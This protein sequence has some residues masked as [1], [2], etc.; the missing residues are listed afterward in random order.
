MREHE[1]ARHVVVYTTDDG[2][3][4]TWGENVLLHR[5]QNG[6]FSTRLFSL[7]YVHVHF[8]PIKVGVIRRTDCRV[9]SE[10]LA[11]HNLDPVCHDAHAVQRR[12]TVEEH[13][14]AVPEMPLH[15]PAWFN[16]IGNR[17]EITFCKP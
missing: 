16:H 1:Y 2:A 8:I 4:E 17:I 12:L 6:C 10:G 3:T 13:D 14:I 7:R 15:S 11:F 9:E 5:D